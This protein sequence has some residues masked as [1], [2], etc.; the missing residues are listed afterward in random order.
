MMRKV[1]LVITIALITVNSYGQTPNWEWARTATNFGHG[2]EGFAVTTDLFGNVFATGF[3]E[4]SLIIF[5]SDT[6]TNQYFYIVK[7]DSSGNVIFAK[8]AIGEAI[9]YGI[10]T[11]AVGNIYVTGQFSS[12]SVTF[13]SYTLTNSGANDLFL[14][15]YNS[16]GVVQWLR[17]AIGSG[18]ED[19]NS[20]ATD[21]FGNVFITGESWS[22][23]L[24][25]G[26]DT[27]TRTGT[28]F[29]YIVKYDSLGNVIFAKTANVSPLANGA[30]S[31]SISADISGNSYITGT[32]V[33][34]GAQTGVSIS[35]DTI[36]LIDSTNVFFITKYNPLGIALWAKKA[37]EP[38]LGNSSGISITA[39]NSEKIYVTGNFN[40]TSIS[41]DTF[42]ITNIGTTNVFLTKYDSLGNVLFAKGIG[43]TLED[44]SYSIASDNYDNVYITGQTDT[45]LMT[46]DTITLQIPIGPDPMFFTKYNSS[47]HALFAIAFPSGADDQNAVAVN[48]SGN[49]FICGDFFQVNPF[50]IGSDSLPLTGTDAES[51]FIAK[52]GLIN[53]IETGK[54]ETNTTPPAISLYP[55]P[56]NGAFTFS[57]HLNQSGIPNSELLITDV[58]GRTLYSYSI[59][60][61]EGQE[62][63]TLPL[64]NGIY[65]WQLLNEGIIIGNGKLLI[66]NNEK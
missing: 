62:T 12:S 13:G 11:D 49:A 42:S 61:L 36:T 22:P 29:L 45:S 2:T 47:G 65:F 66:I 25:F 63:L 9:G 32:F 3:F 56:N 27:L 48:N 28:T 43:E 59:N 33:G 1:F 46:L 20:V 14:V 17:G 30:Y 51:F 53:N 41:F 40:G 15:K 64:S 35:F 52:L 50:I 60:N 4:D 24:I 44:Q 34:G 26:M 38:V 23:M 55:N 8:D 6:L 31:N 21:N 16:L 37:I 10:A 57:Y 7:Y 39:T 19:A 54:Q 58:T 18:T 5:G